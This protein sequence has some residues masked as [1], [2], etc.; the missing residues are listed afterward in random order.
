MINVRERGKVFAHTEFL[1]GLPCSIVRTFARELQVKIPWTSL[2]SEPIEILLDTVECICKEE[3]GQDL[4]VN[5]DTEDAFGSP[6]GEEDLHPKSGTSAQTESRGAG[7]LSTYMKQALANVT[8]RVKNLVCKYIRKDAVFT[9]SVESVVTYSAGDDWLKS[10]VDAD[11]ALRRV[12]TVSGITVC[13]DSA[14]RGSQATN[15]L[16]PVLRNSSCSIKFALHSTSA[17]DKHQCLLEVSVSPWLMNIR[18]SQLEQMMHLIVLLKASSTSRAQSM[19]SSSSQESMEEASS[20]SQASIGLQNGHALADSA[21][22]DLGISPELEEPI[23]AGKGGSNAIGWM[24]NFL[25]N[26]E[27]AEQGAQAAELRRAAVKQLEEE[28]GRI[29][30]GAILDISVQLVSQEGVMKLIDDEVDMQ[31]QV[32]AGTGGSDLEEVQDETSSP[33]GSREDVQQSMAQVSVSQ[34]SPSGPHVGY[35]LVKWRHLELDC[36]MGA[37]GLQAVTVK[38]T[39]FSLASPYGQQNGEGDTVLAE[40]SPPQGRQGFMECLESFRD[41]QRLML[42]TCFPSE[43]PSPVQPPSLAELP[44]FMSPGTGSALECG[45]YRWGLDKQVKPKSPQ[46]DKER[47]RSGYALFLKMGHVTYCH[48]VAVTDKLIL[49]SS[50]LKVNSSDST[51]DQTQERRVDAHGQ[52]GGGTTPARSGGK[53]A[54]QDANSQYLVLLLEASHLWFLLE[55][56]QVAVLSSIPCIAPQALILASDVLKADMGCGTSKQHAL[57]FSLTELQLAAC[58][59]WA[60]MKECMSP[61]PVI[62]PLVLSGYLEH[63]GAADVLPAGILQLKYCLATERLG[64][65]LESSTCT[66]F[67]RVA[68]SLLHEKLDLQRAMECVAALPPEG[69]WVSLL[70]EGLA[71]E[72]EVAL[73][74]CLPWATAVQVRHSK[75]DLFGSRLSIEPHEMVVHGCSLSLSRSP[76]AADVEVRVDIGAFSSVLLAASCSLLVH[77]SQLRHCL[78]YSDANE[79]NRAQVMPAQKKAINQTTTAHLAATS[80]LFVA[81]ELEEEKHAE[82]VL[83]SPVCGHPA[84]RITFASTKFRSEVQVPGIDTN[85][86]QVHEPGYPDVSQQVD[87]CTG[88]GDIEGGL[89]AVKARGRVRMLVDEVKRDVWLDR[90]IVSIG[91]VAPLEHNTREV[92]GSTGLHVIGGAVLDIQDVHLLFQKTPQQ[93][94]EVEVADMSASLS[95]AQHV[96]LL[97]FLPRFPQHIADAWKSSQ[98][99]SMEKHPPST[100]MKEA[101][102]RSSDPMVE[103]LQ[104]GG[105]ESVQAAPAQ[106]LS[107][108]FLKLNVEVAL[109][110]DN[111]DYAPAVDPALLGETSTL[112]LII[113]ELLIIETRAGSKR[114]ASEIQSGSGSSAS[115]A[116]GQAREVAATIAYIEVVTC[117]RLCSS[118]EGE[119][120]VLHAVLRPIDTVPAAPTPAFCFKSTAGDEEAAKAVLELDSFDWWLDA[121]LL[122]EIVTVVWE[123]RKGQPP[124]A[125]PDVLPGTISARF[126]SSQARLHLCTA[127]EAAEQGLLV[128]AEH[129]VG[130][131]HDS[132]GAD[133]RRWAGVHNGAYPPGVMDAH[134]LKVQNFDLSILGWQTA[135]L[136]SAS[137]APQTFV[138]STDVHVAG[139]L[140]GCP[141]PVLIDLD[142][143]QLHLHLSQPLVRQLMSPLMALLNAWSATWPLRLRTAGM[144][145]PSDDLRSGAFSRANVQA[146]QLERGEVSWGDTGAAALGSSTK[147]GGWIVWRYPFPRKAALVLLTGAC[148]A[149]SENGERPC[150]KF[151]LSMYDASKSAYCDV[152]TDASFQGNA[153]SLHMAADAHLEAEEWM[154]SWAHPG[155]GIQHV[156]AS[157]MLLLLQVNPKKGDA[158]GSLSAAL[159]PPLMPFLLFHLAAEDLHVA[160]KTLGLAGLATWVTLLGEKT[161]TAFHLWSSVLWSLHGAGALCAEYLDMTCYTHEVLVEPFQLAYS[162][163]YSA[164]LE[165]EM[166]EVSRQASE[167]TTPTLPNA[168]HRAPVLPGYA[169]QVHISDEVVWRVHE[170]AVRE[171]QR[172]VSRFQQQQ[173]Q[174]QPGDRLGQASDSNAPSEPGLENGGNAE[175]ASEYAA[176]VIENACSISLVF[177]Q[178]QLGILPV[179]PEDAMSSSLRTSVHMQWSEPVDISAE[180]AFQHVIPISATTVVPVVIAVKRG[181]H[182]QMHA[183]IKPAV[184]IVNR[185]PTMLLVRFRGLLPVV[186]G[187][188]PHGGAARVHARADLAS[189]DI[190]SRIDSPREGSKARD[191]VV[192]AVPSS[193]AGEKKGAYTEGRD[194]LFAVPKASEKAVSGPVG[195]VSVFLGAEGNW[196]QPTEL[197]AQCFDASFSRSFL[198]SKEASTQWHNAPPTHKQQLL[199][200]GGHC[201]WLQVTVTAWPLFF[202]ASGLHVALEVRVTAKAADSCIM[203]VAHEDEL[204]LDVPALGTHSLSLRLVS[205]EPH[206]VQSSRRLY[207]HEGAATIAHQVPAAG[208]HLTLSLPF[209]APGSDKVLFCALVARQY[210]RDVPAVLLTVMPYAVLHNHLPVSVAIAADVLRCDATVSAWAL[211][212]Q[213]VP[214]AWNGLDGRRMSTQICARLGLNVGLEAAVGSSSSSNSGQE[215]AMPRSKS[216]GASAEAGG[217]AWSAPLRVD[218]SGVHSVVVIAL[219]Q[220][221]P[222]EC[223]FL[224][225][226]KYESYGEVDE[227]AQL[228]SFQCCHMVVYPWAVIS[229]ELPLD[230]SVHLGGSPGERRAYSSSQAKAAASFVCIGKSRCWPILA[231]PWRQGTA[232][233][234]QT[235]PSPKS[236]VAAAAA[237]A[238]A[239]GSADAAAAGFRCNICLAMP[240]SSEEAEPVWSVAMDISQPALGH[241]LMLPA[242]AAGEGHARMLTCTVVSREQQVHV[243]VYEDKQ[244]PCIIVNHTSLMLEVA[245]PENSSLVAHVPRSAQLDF[246]WRKSTL[247]QYEQMERDVGRNAE[248]SGTGRGEGAYEED[249]DE[250]LLL[251]MKRGGQAGEVRLRALGATWSKPIPL[252]AV[253]SLH[254]CC[255]FPAGSPDANVFFSVS[256]VQAGPTF[257][258][259]VSPPEHMRC[260]NAQQ[261]APR[262]PPATLELAIH[263]FKVKIWDDEKRTLRGPLTPFGSQACEPAFILSAER[264]RLSVAR[265]EAERRPRMPQTIAQ[266]MRLSVDMLQLDSLLPGAELPRRTYQQQE[267]EQ[268]PL[269]ATRTR[270]RNEARIWCSRPVMVNIDDTLVTL[271]YRIMRGRTSAGSADELLLQHPPHTLTGARALLWAHGRAATPP[272]RD[273]D[274]SLV[275][276]RLYVEAVHVGNL[277]LLATVHVS[278][279]AVLD[280][281]QAPVLVSGL[282][283]RQLLFPPLVL[284]RGMLAHF[285][286]EGVLNAPRLVGS[287]DIIFNPTG[288][289][290]SVQAGLRDLVTLPIQGIQGLAR[291][292]A[293]VFTAPL[294]GAVSGGA[295]GLLLGVGKGLVGAIAGPV[296]GALQLVALTSQGFLGTSG[297]PIPRHLMPSSPAAA[298][299]A[300]DGRGQALRLHG[301]VLTQA[302]R[303]SVFRFK[304]QILA[305]TVERYVGHAEVEA[306]VLT[307][308]ECSSPQL[309]TRPVL[310]LTHAAL[311]VLENAGIL[312]AARLPLLG[313]ELS[314]DGSDHSITTYAALHGQLFERGSLAE[315]GGECGPVQL[316]ARLGQAP[317]LSWLPMLRRAAVS[318][319]DAAAAPDALSASALAEDMGYVWQILW[320]L[321][322]EVLRHI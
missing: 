153:L 306:A 23:P 173:Q 319:A 37:T 233:S 13:I 113:R 204:A 160:I 159:L 119:A 282:D 215:G 196:S 315:V 143:Q 305:S 263:V 252:V 243:L 203:E 6:T 171:L 220:D 190:V 195:Q 28:A 17:S 3:T 261:P 227:G 191:N 277:S 82:W 62:G 24:W 59:T 38:L 317:W 182:M 12:C 189:A 41:E 133:I 68:K 148:F 253:D 299:S 228:G 91:T 25:A 43:H 11:D 130:I 122:E 45:W 128:T 214:F 115:G 151:S 267:Q 232:P 20:N 108:R 92:A 123:R 295:T 286:T 178:L 77:A 240:G 241:R 174:Q 161:S 101:M 126:V 4:Q 94:V 167:P 21:L 32:Y 226:F 287:L 162:L 22:A 266:S 200:S 202:F 311:H 155:D 313:L 104:P 60:G 157:E 274:M 9:L 65:H 251:H 114:A 47:R 289:V 249:L 164:A 242:A 51:S 127:F 172:G 260:D 84:A 236:R 224:V 31:E 271:M 102:A 308:T 107:V 97:R 230:L 301:L 54:H 198:V 1:K 303:S 156:Q 67:L 76:H 213:K 129:C 218:S 145:P 284:L 309:L 307:S 40:L 209:P 217:W 132:Q 140:L 321:Y 254:V 248:G 87:G 291:S 96:L 259:H 10:Y 222:T 208:S 79:A 5:L 279:P 166:E 269:V 176:F 135:L 106:R 78:V 80:V 199:P 116:G 229:N 188:D 89:T 245:G 206:S 52:P 316:Y 137:A 270:R 276:A 278:W 105:L 36:D 95:R 61:Q 42:Q 74:P 221:G 262:V 117:R 85:T 300:G 168:L 322:F 170:S 2:A 212:A 93:V 50:A 163:E 165:E 144:T 71:V 27:A 184:Q 110:R 293:G 292:V 147:Q 150:Y 193:K 26:A 57:R 219:S 70:L 146:Q 88:V 48:D 318:A 118:C 297:L 83:D 49:W 35:F 64:F 273:L 139:K 103:T 154:L 149:L 250:A 112:A 268:H 272:E 136:S 98:D 187:K 237:A 73:A 81:D 302:T 177:G 247:S 235:L 56:C 111:L 44:T 33:E 216:I 180:A 90:A 246:D 58:H 265:A 256:V 186:G 281:N 141:G 19:S 210:A 120:S 185:T 298:A 258:L 194:I 142:T 99:P 8:L 138:S 18:R 152:P 63:A 192:I 280:T 125:G 53:H 231:F 314:E 29:D 181:T 238:A 66:L 134:S 283:L 100:N 225:R 257:M 290:R 16:E 201:M 239:N 320:P 15:F 175:H 124:A 207:G 69:P 169:A 304:H 234:T 131:L 197:T 72:G 294:Q 46:V 312:V 179:I 121:Q 264:L 75:F 86:C 205:E 55:G 158:S 285:V 109:W 223:R 39:H 211:P 30:F 34:S 7:W 310:L 288:L 183:V 296:S 275:Q 14:L 244:P 255:E